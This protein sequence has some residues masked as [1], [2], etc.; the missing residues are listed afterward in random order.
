MIPLAY[1][2]A[3]LSIID[4]KSHRLPNKLVG[5]FT[6]TEI[7]I[8]AV[9]SWMASDFDRF[10]TALGIAGVTTI[11]YLLLYLVSRGSLGM[12]D[13]KFAFPLGLC[14]GWYSA[15]QWLV[16]IFISFLIAGLVAVI[17]LVTKRIT[18][19]SRLAFGPY[20]FLGTFL[21]CV[22]EVL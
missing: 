1:F 17:G 22:F 16:A 19:K 9:I 3:Q 8:M 5:W 12:G 13:V 20:M 7:L 10:G 6:A 21:V 4:F 15:N 14:V 11:V 18:R 2:G